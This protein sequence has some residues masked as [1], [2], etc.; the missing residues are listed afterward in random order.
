MGWGKAQPP[1]TESPL[2]DVGVP[3]PSV[4]EALVRLELT[5]L[6]RQLTQLTRQHPAHPAHMQV[7]PSHAPAHPAQEAAH[8]AQPALAVLWLQ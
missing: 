3:P 6:M 5:Q 1:P 4:R 2:G 8:L 7:H